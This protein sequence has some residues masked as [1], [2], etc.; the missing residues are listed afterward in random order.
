L[1]ITE[2][3]FLQTI[4]PR[5]PNT[6]ISLMCCKINVS[7]SLAQNVIFNCEFKYKAPALEKDD[8]RETVWNLITKKFNMRPV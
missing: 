5:K 1:K 4:A 6:S 8:G 3:F 2:F 7:Y